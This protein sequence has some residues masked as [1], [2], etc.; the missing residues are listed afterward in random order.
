MAAARTSV[1]AA[2]LV[3]LVC[4]RL[5]YLGWRRQLAVADNAHNNREG[6][7]VCDLL[8]RCFVNRLRLLFALLWFVFVAL[9][10]CCCCCLALR[11]AGLSVGLS[12]ATGR[13]HTQQ[14]AARSG[15][16]VRITCVLH[17]QELGAR[18]VVAS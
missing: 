9:A 1:R 14:A 4:W 7:V 6:E 12:R 8:L 15:L 16:C 11:A 5:I 10:V 18:Y 3:P 13:T 2:P 17:E